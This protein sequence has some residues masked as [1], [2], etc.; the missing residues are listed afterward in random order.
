MPRR[1]IFVAAAAGDA[2]T[3]RWWLT[4]WPGAVAEKDD[5]EHAHATALHRAARAASDRLHIVDMLLAAGADVNAQDA[6]KQTPLHYAAQNNQVRIVKL[7]LVAGA[8]PAAMDVAYLTPIHYTEN[9]EIKT[10]LRA[11][12]VRRAASRVKK[13]KAN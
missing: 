3:V 6:M 10:L 1:K 11:A 2:K 8:N 13:S 5:D 4:F 9:D 7:L 12:G